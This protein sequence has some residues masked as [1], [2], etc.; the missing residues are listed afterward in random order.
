MHSAL[1]MG[2]S[3]T[4][5]TVGLEFTVEHSGNQIHSLLRRGNQFS[6]GARLGYIYDILN[7][8]FFTF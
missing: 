5:F 6:S 1:L 4:V 8:V 3:L 2:W 7:L